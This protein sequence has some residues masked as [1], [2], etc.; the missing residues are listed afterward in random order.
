MFRVRGFLDR[1]DILAV[2]QFHEDR[3]EALGDGVGNGRLN[4]GGCIGGVDGGLGGHIGSPN[5]DNTARGEIDVSSLDIKYFYDGGGK[6]LAFDG[7]I[8]LGLFWLERYIGE[9]V[10]RGP[11]ADRQ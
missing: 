1:N 10:R 4:V 9:I 2:G 6:Y 8:L 7:N 3:I 5:Y 11:V